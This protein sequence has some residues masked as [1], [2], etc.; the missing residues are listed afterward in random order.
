MI[1]SRIESSSK[2]LANNVDAALGNFGTSIFIT[3]E[4]CGPMGQ[5]SVIRSYTWGLSQPCRI[6]D[7]KE[8]RG[9]QREQR[10]WGSRGP[11]HIKLR[12]K[13]WSAEM[14]RNF[15]IDGCLNATSIGGNGDGP[16]KPGWGSCSNAHSTNSLEFTSA[17]LHPV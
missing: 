10:N 13:L 8:R 3:R 17:C 12:R 5:A 9:H 11:V 2:K 7:D 15:T 4:R 16:C 14:V 6:I 1:V